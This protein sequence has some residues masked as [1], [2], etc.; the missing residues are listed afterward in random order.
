MDFEL[1]PKVKDY[2]R[3]VSEFMDRYVYPIEKQVEEEMSVPGKEH[4]EPQVL[5]EVRAKAKAAG[6][7]NLFA[8]DEYGKGLKVAEYAPLCEIMGRSPIGARA[9]NCMAPDT[10]NMEILMDFGTPEQKKRWLEPCLNGEMRTCLPRA[11]SAK[12]TTTISTGTNGSPP[13][14]LAP[15]SPL[16]WWSRTP[17]PSRIGA[18]A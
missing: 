1:S 15:A 7:W 10:G 16:R 2:Q 12:A 13:A 11:P 9:F 17:M 3:Q 6:L 5:K 8:P 18:P 4:T 14:R